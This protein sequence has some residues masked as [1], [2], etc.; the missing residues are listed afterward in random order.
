M[1]AVQEDNLSSGDVSH[2]HVEC[3][4]RASGMKAK[5]VL[6]IK[7]VQN[8][9]FALSLVESQDLPCYLCGKKIEDDRSIY[10]RPSK[11]GVSTLYRLFRKVGHR[12]YE[13]HPLYLDCG[14]GSR[15]RAE[16]RAREIERQHND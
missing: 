15:A 9:T 8:G 6:S 10:V 1:I 14:F 2:A 5:D 13:L 7:N 4:C 3:F 12:K 11:D 16:R